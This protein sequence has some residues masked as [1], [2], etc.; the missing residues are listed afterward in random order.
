MEVKVGK[1][2]ALVEVDIL[3]VVPAY[4]TGGKTFFIR[5][6]PTVKDEE[7]LVLVESH[8]R[9]YAVKYTLKVAKKK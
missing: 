4:K 9:P 6:K 3:E 2:T 1:D 5:Q 7:S 8:G